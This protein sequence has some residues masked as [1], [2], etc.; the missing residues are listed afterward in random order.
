MDPPC[1]LSTIAEIQKGQGLGSGYEWLAGLVSRVCMAG[2]VFRVC[3]GGPNISGVQIWRDRSPPVTF[4]N[5]SWKAR[6]N[7]S[8]DREINARSTLFSDFYTYIIAYNLWDLE[9]DNN[10]HNVMHGCRYT[11]VHHSKTYSG[12]KFSQRA[13][14]QFSQYNV[15]ACRQSCPFYTVQ[16]FRGLNFH[17]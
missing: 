5:S 6:P 7:N 1:I 2:L 17:G 14:H 11:Y 12:V 3:K 10:K 4:S 16:N 15:H 9:L 13:C 8:W